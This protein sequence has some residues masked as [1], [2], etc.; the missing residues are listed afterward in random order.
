LRNIL[1]YFNIFLWGKIAS[2]SNLVSDFKDNQEDGNGANIL[3]YVCTFLE[4]LM[5]YLLVGCLKTLKEKS[6]TKLLAEAILPH[7]K[8]LK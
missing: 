7:R 2:A 3:C 8:M 4:N 1:N 6:L 5:F